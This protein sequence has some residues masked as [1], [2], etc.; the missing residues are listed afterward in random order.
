MK[1]YTIFSKDKEKAY[2]KIQNPF[3]VE[4]KK[5]TLSK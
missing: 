3:R 1:N 5:N 4:K 2:V